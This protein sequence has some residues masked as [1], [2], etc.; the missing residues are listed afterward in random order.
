MNPQVC[1]FIHIN[2]I[3]LLTIYLY[4]FVGNKLTTAFSKNLVVSFDEVEALNN[5][6]KT[7]ANNDC[8]SFRRIFTPIVSEYQIMA[9][10]LI[11]ANNDPSISD[12]GMLD[13]I[14]VQDREFQYS[15]LNPAAIFMRKDSFHNCDLAEVNTVFAIQMMLQTL[16]KENKSVGEFGLYML[17]WHMSPIF[18]YT[19][20]EPC[21]SR[22]TKHMNS[23]M[24]R[25]INATDPAR[26]ILAH[27][28]R[29]ANNDP[30]TMQTFQANLQ[31]AI[32]Q[33][34]TIPRNNFNTILHDVRDRLKNYIYIEN[35]VEYIKVQV[36]L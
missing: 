18:A 4:L 20:N 10:A 8:I 5:N 26:Y 2:I 28:L 23:T 24:A 22:W 19:Q 6:V 34:K 36:I 11:A 31:T 35:K 29:P 21:T 13:R 14:K 17:I 27:K 16:P 3:L 9:T 30:I 1:F 33:D 32:V 7:L 25:F 15:S 12:I